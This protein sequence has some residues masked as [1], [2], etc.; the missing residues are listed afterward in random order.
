LPK[1]TDILGIGLRVYPPVPLNNRTAKK[2]TILPVGGGPDGTDPILVRKGE[3]VVYSQYVNSRVRCIYGQD[4]N[5]FRPDRW[6]SEE[7]AKIGWA[8]FP[9]SGG[10]RRCLGEDFALMEIS[11]TIVR[12]IQVTTSIKLPDDEPV[13]V[14]GQEKQRLT[15]VL[16]PADGCRVSLELS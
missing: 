2:T 3:L 8:Y 9:F 4:A 16:A 1:G 15:L 6:E 14:I 7:L 5:D 12:L 11:Y 13:G 10:P